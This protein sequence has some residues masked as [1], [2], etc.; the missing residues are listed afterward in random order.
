MRKRSDPE[1]LSVDLKAP[2]NFKGFLA[3]YDEMAGSVR[4]WLDRFSQQRPNDEGVRSF[5]QVAPSE[6]D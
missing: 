3:T 6:I 4:R 1:G 2:Q 5:I